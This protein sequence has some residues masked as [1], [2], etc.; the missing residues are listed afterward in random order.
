MKAVDS[1]DDSLEPLF[2]MVPV[3]IVE[4]SAQI[5][6]SKGSQIAASI[7]EKLCVDGGGEPCVLAIYLEFTHRQPYRV[8]S[9]R[10]TANGCRRA[11]ILSS[12]LILHV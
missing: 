8:K 10:E 9:N 6:P 1:H 2:D 11:L 3:V 12:V 7:D 4:M 5:V